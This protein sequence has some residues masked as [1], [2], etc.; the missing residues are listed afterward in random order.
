MS[1]GHQISMPFA[2]GLVALLTAL[3]LGGVLTAWVQRPSRRAVNATASKDE[4]LRPDEIIAA[5]PREKR[6]PTP[7]SPVGSIRYSSFGFVAQAPVTKSKDATAA[8]VIDRPQLSS[9]MPISQP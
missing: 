4:P 3:G 1:A 2:E 6:T 7:F 9:A 5:L 8:T